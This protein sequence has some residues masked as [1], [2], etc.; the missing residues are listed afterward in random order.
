MKKDIILVYLLGGLSQRLGG[1]IKPLAPIGPHNEP[2]LEISLQ[3]S[4]PAYFSKII[5][6]V[7]PVTIKAYQ[8]HFGSHYQGIPIEYTLQTYDSS[9]RDKPWGTADALCAAIPFLNTP[10]IIC[11]EDDLYGS[12]SF[13]QAKNFLE[14]TEENLVIGYELKEVVPTKGAVNRAIIQTDTKEKISDIHEEFNIT[15]EKI[16]KRE[17]R[18]NALC[19]MNFFGIQPI[20][21]P[22]IQRKVQQ[23]KKENRNNR[24]KECLLP[25]VINILIHKGTAFRVLPAHERWIGI[26]FAADIETAKSQ[27]YT[28][29]QADALYE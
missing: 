10:S 27:L 19:S 11:N 13:E 15:L 29:S 23:F 2:L 21:L 12:S 8:H 14:Q 18:G 1:G 4:L 17:L 5:F 6:I 25:E 3:Q 26:T 9:K 24:T 22:E 28:N 7:S 16:E 20:L